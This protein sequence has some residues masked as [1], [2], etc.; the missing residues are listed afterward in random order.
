MSKPPPPPPPPVVHVS[1]Q[2]PGEP[3][4]SLGW[5]LTVITVFGA[6]IALAVYLWG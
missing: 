5:T 1:M 3:W 4:R 6:I 2:D